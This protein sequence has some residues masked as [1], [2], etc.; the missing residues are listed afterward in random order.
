MQNLS[1]LSPCKFLSFVSQKGASAQIFRTNLNITQMKPFQIHI[2]RTPFAQE[3]VLPVLPLSPGH[4]FQSQKACLKSAR[5][6]HWQN[7]LFP[8]SHFSEPKL[9]AQFM[10]PATKPFR[11]RT[12]ACCNTHKT[13]HNWIN[14]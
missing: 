9:R 1:L 4:C 3:S 13:E 14:R 5:V 12:R 2:F 6:E 10:S 7:A 8:V 11:V